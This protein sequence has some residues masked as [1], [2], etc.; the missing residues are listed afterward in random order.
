M[1]S[2]SLSTGNLSAYFLPLTIL[3]AVLWP[4]SI[5]LLRGYDRSIIGVGSDELRAVLRA[6]VVVVVIGAFPAGWF[7]QQTLITLLAVATPFALALSTLVRLVAQGAP[8]SSA[9]RTQLPSHPCRGFDACGPGAEQSDRQ[10]ASWRYARRW[11]LS[12]PMG[13]HRCR[14]PRRT[15]CRHLGFGGTGCRQP[16][17]RRRRRD[18][19]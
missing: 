15:G 17:G 18:Q 3:G 14:R 12:A 9:R 19:R 11:C 10:G 2:H 13:G 4:L 5:L 7:Q 8:S 1:I 6:G 16:P